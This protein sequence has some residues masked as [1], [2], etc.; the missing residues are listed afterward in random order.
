VHEALW[1]DAVIEKLWAAESIE[2]G[3]TTWYLLYRDPVHKR[4]VSVCAV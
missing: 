1:G 3:A 2:D 4:P